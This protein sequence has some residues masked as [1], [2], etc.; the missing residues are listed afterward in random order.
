MNS[1]KGFTLI[2]LMISIVLGLLVTAAAVQLF[3]TGMTSYNMQK[4]G[5]EVQ[6]NGLFGL[7]VIAQSLRLANYH[8]ISPIIN[9]QTVMG[10]LVLSSDPADIAVPAGGSIDVPGNLEGVRMAGAVVPNGLISRGDGMTV[11]SGNQWTGVS[12]VTLS[13]GT[14]VNSDQL[15]IQ[16][17]A[18]QDMYDCE[19]NFVR[20]PRTVKKDA[21]FTEL[22][23]AEKA[24]AG[25]TVMDNTLDVDGD[26]VVERYFLRP[27]TIAN[28]NEPN[29][30]LALVC[31]AGR[32][33]TKDP[34]KLGANGLLLDS[35]ALNGNISYGDAGQIIMNRV[36][37]FHVLLGVH[38]GN[39]RSRLMY[40]PINQY[41]NIVVPNNP[42][43][44]PGPRPRIVSVQISVLARS[45]T[46]S[47]N[48]L[49]D[50]SGNFTMLDQTVKLKSVS[51]TDSNRYVRQVYAATIAVR[52]GLG[53]S[54]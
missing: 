26:V 47:K 32:Y 4:S 48:K 29:Q 2:E 3:I 1:A 41:M 17:R 25:T 33:V 50:P 15:V 39:D 13:T 8:S 31:D 34:T 35:A 37:H 5:A 44:S 19:G 23:D 36:D 20:G 54:L 51:N 11:A 45:M 43:G 18:P 12:N 16:Y 46:N 40:Y 24:A 52:N 14:A 30:P 22:T 42:D 6:E 28:S 49:L 21:S 10:G 9:D 53:E 7:E 27:D 38:P